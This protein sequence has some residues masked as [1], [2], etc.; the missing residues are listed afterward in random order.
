MKFVAANDVPA[1]TVCDVGCATTGVGFT[2]IV[3]DLLGPAHEAAEGVT[4]SVAVA[5]ELPV[6][7][8]LNCAILPVPLAARPIDV[9]VFVQV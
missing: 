2:V 1:Q 4:V 8:P 7:M 3:K 6:L 9:F 5:T